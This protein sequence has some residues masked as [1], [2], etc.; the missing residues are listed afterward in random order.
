MVNSIGLVI[1]ATTVCIV[2][3]TF[4]YNA[5]A[6]ILDPNASMKNFAHGDETQMS[7]Q[8][9]PSEIS[10][11]APTSSVPYFDTFGSISLDLQDLKSQQLSEDAIYQVP[12]AE[13]NIK[14]YF[15]AIM[16]TNHN[17]QD[18]LLSLYIPYLDN[19][20]K[21]LSHPNEQNLQHTMQLPGE[22]GVQY[23]SL[24]EIRSKVA[25]LKKLGVDIVSYDLEKDGSPARDL[26]NPVTSVK[27]ASDIVHRNGLKFM[28][29]PSRE[30]TS[31]YG[32]QF[33]KFVDIYDVQA[34]SL[35]SKPNEYKNYV[36]QIVKKLRSS[37]AEISISAQVST[38]R[39]SLDSMK[40]SISLVAESVD[41][42]TSWYSGDQKA[43]AKLEGFV[44]WFSDKYK[45]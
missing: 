12:Q 38:D 29:A 24:A 5:H 28:V 11:S 6:G 22:H 41:G 16:R 18:D 42:V 10:F 25:T 2:G 43:L 45:N 35:Q 26:T 31:L 3:I 9:E 4:D 36:E 14:K 19:N 17:I 21:I 23:F 13:T 39:G 8:S 37:N 44:K 32:A 30:L 40:N 27:L 20:D 15:I 34:Q 7:Y 1:L 33:A